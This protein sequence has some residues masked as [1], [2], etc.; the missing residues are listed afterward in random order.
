MN[1]ATGV[2]SAAVCDRDCEQ[3]CGHEKGGVGRLTDCIDKPKKKD[4]TEIQ[5]KRMQK[6]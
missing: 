1:D 5:I 2:G 4:E 6:H 3:R